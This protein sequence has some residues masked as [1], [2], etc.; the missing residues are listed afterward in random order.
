[1]AD[2]T[3]HWYR[4]S[5]TNTNTFTTESNTSGD[6]WSAWTINTGTSTS[7]SGAAW[8]TWN[9]GVMYF[10][11]EYILL[12]PEQVA[13]AVGRAAAK[14]EEREKKRLASEARA[15]EL[16]MLALDH[17]QRKDLEAR[18]A[19]R[20]EVL[21]RDGATRRYE[22]TRGRA[23][24]VYEI[25]A[26]GKRIAKFCAH[27]AVDC[28]DQDTMLAQKLMLEADEEAFLAVANRSACA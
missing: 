2:G 26:K 9:T 10:A 15:K 13:Q 17:L 23:G 8:T 22:I 28:P 14:A 6:P 21:S 16:L 11:R 5:T 27:P 24:N 7:M 25:D 18:G 19:F 1:M 12:T 20:L 3:W 4:D